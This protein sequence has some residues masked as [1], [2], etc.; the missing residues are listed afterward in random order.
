LSLIFPFHRLGDRTNVS[1]YD[2]RPGPF[3]LGAAE[4]WFFGL[5][6]IVDCMV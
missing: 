3:L 1:G 4:V 5:R 2:A 6:M